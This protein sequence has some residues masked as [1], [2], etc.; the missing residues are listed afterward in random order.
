MAGV[1]RANAEP[2]HRFYDFDV[3]DA[4]TGSAAPSIFRKQSTSLRTAAR[5]SG[6]R[7]HCVPGSTP[8]AAGSCTCFVHFISNDRI[9]AAGKFPDGQ[10]EVPESVGGQA[11]TDD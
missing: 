11:K 4:A 9:H 10:G 3:S 8:M 7:D 6:E 2:R 1:A 5:R